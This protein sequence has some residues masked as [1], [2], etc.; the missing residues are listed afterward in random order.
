[1]RFLKLAGTPVKNASLFTVV[2]LIAL[3]LGSRIEWIWKSHGM[4]L[5][6]SH[7]ILWTVNYDPVASI[8]SSIQR[9]PNVVN[10]FWLIP[11]QLLSIPLRKNLLI[12]YHS[13]RLLQKGIWQDFFRFVDHYLFTV[14][15]S[16]T[17][18]FSTSQMKGSFRQLISSPLGCFNFI[19]FA[20]SKYL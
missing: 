13:P 4:L 15:Q 6:W 10:C 8:F 7:A 2:G 19:V 14:P 17:H 20:K 18:F 1:M 12:N 11:F 3:T 5:L 16:C 9:P